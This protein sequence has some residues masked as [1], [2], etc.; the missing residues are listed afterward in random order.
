[1]PL[2]SY[3]KKWHGHF[4]NLP[5]IL[6][7]QNYCTSNPL[8]NFWHWCSFLS[9]ALSDSEQKMGS[10][11]HYAA[12]K[13]FLDCKECKLHQRN[14]VNWGRSKSIFLSED[15]CKNLVTFYVTCNLYSFIQ[16]VVLLETRSRHNSYWFSRYKHQEYAR[17]FL[18]R[19]LIY[20]IK[21][22][23]SSFYWLWPFNLN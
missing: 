17:F 20:H 11:C 19:P 9:T 14:L 4:F 7:S 3:R 12:A 15:L 1:M 5:W 13:F 18:D 21:L 6:P 10:Y 8:V 2:L 22:F 16:R 23:F